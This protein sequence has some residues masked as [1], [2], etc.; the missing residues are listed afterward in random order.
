VAELES[1][2]THG[3]GNEC[4]LRAGTSTAPS[5]STGR[6]REQAEFLPCKGRQ[7][8]L[9]ATVVLST[10]GPGTVA[11]LSI[12]TSA[13]GRETTRID[14]NATM[15]TLD[16]RQ[17]S[18]TPDSNSSGAPNVKNWFPQNRTRLYAPLADALPPTAESQSAVTFS[19]RVFV[20]G[21]VLEVFVNE[22]VALTGLVF[23]TLE[24]AIHIRTPS[25]EVTALDVW[26]LQSAA[27][28]P[29]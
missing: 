14:L 5:I 9:N 3:T 19:V 16:R 1:L 7:L 6:S 22:R 27:P 12:L 11:S 25:A 29:S 28:I 24:D 23:P 26:L 10:I 21:S 18:L 8:E 13:D 20:D 17:S 4:H 15:L 2:R